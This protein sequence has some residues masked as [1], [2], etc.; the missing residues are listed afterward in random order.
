MGL[1]DISSG[2]MLIGAAVSSRLLENGRYADIVSREFSSITCENEM[3]P[4][5]ILDR[6]A[7]LKAG[8]DGRAALDFTNANKVMDFAKANGIK[9]RFHVLVW[10]N[11]TPRW[12]F[13]ENWSMDADAP[14]VKRDTL[15]KRM[16]NYI[17]DVMGYVNTAYP[18][19]VYCWD[20]LNEFIEPDNEHPNGCR[21]R[22]NNWFAVLGEDVPRCAFT[23]ARRY[24]A[25][26][27]KLFY[28]DYNEY[29]Q[30]KRDFIIKM[31]RPLIADGLVDGMGLQS[32]L[33]MD[34]PSMDEYKKAI[35]DYANEG[36]SLQITELDIKSLDPSE[37]GERLLARRYAEVFEAAAQSGK[38]ES[39]TLWGVTD[40]QSWLSKP[41]IPAYP[42]LFDR[43]YNPKKAYDAAKEILSR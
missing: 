41:G 8:D 39:L 6:E 16:E 32:H 15:L 31:L 35:R 1:K 29:E 10:H 36:L 21:V 40:A 14:L 43:D 19:L 12:F 11:Q 7:T 4:E 26:G 30:P 42:L 37:E 38:V 23:F 3:K 20:V 5:C 9:L 18:G 25:P 34:Y 27:Q 28:N 33:L 17:K 2:K 22:K 13:A 24:C